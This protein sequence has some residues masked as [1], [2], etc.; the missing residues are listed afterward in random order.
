M[1]ANPA[2]R[3]TNFHGTPS[4]DTAYKATRT[5]QA[6]LTRPPPEAPL[7]P[8]DPSHNKTTNGPTDNMHR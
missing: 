5:V 8:D 4:V 7:T 2:K 3:P 1:T 6:P